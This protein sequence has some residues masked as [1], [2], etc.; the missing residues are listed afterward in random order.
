M[1]VINRLEYQLKKQWS[2]LNKIKD[3][4][5]FQKARAEAL[6]TYQTLKRQKQ[7]IGVL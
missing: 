6:K 2:E 3:Q 5:A 7:L 4:E 1:E